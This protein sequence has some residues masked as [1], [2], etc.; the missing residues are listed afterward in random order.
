MLA[1]NSFIK[2]LRTV[3]EQ[4]N[5]C[6]LCCAFKTQFPAAFLWAIKD[7]SGCGGD[8]YRAQKFP[9]IYHWLEC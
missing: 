9:F 1:Q 4:V 7:Y 2:G 8:K 6:C 3:R 5:N